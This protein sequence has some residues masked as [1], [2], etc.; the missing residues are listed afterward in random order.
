M[1]AMLSFDFAV[2][3]RF[4]G[5]ML[6]IQAGVPGGVF[7]HDSRT[8]ELCQTMG[9][10]VRVPGEV[11]AGFGLADLHALFPLDV[12]AFAAIRERLR[13]VYV[14]LLRGCGVEPSAR[15]TTLQAA[16]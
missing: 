8:L 6:A 5:V 13:R 4:H 1:D 15:L 16:A 14:D 7:A 2:G 3:A 12:A 9:L 11:P 10:P